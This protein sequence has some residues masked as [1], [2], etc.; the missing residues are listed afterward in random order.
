[1][2]AEIA[3]F[4]ENPNFGKFGSIPTCHDLFYSV[5]PKRK[6]KSDI[7][8]QNSFDNQLAAMAE[9]TEIQAELQKINYEFSVTES[10]GLEFEYRWISHKNWSKFSLT[11]D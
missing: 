5:L 8:K 3:R 2:V 11:A 7:S 10:D 6:I 4:R 1:L 9:D